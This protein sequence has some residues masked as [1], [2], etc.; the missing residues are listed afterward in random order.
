MLEGS[1]AHA[2][3]LYRRGTAYMLA[4][5]FEEA[6][7]DFKRV[8]LPHLLMREV[9]AEMI[10]VLSASVFQMMT[11]DKSSE[12]DATAALLKLKQ[13]EQVNEPLPCRVASLFRRAACLPYEAMER[14]KRRRRPRGN[15]RGFSTKSRG[16]SPKSARTLLQTT[17]PQD[18]ETQ[19]PTWAA[20]P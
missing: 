14:R 8:G 2:K 20:P 1:P 17:S 16:K 18:Q 7:S 12:P 11:V 5:D 3:A 10:S 19:T 4:G 9:N 6:R 13:K 15:S